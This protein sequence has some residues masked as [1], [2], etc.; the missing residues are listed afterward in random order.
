[1]TPKQRDKLRAALETLRAQAL[2]E[3]PNKIEP[4]RKHAATVGVEDE[5]EQA[6]NEMLQTLASERNKAKADQLA[7]ID[8]A[9]VRLDRAPDEFG[10]CEECEEEIAAKRLALMPY[11]TL[12]AECQALRDPRRGG[13]RKSLTDYK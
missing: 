2:A 11:A 3:G 9:L 7:R 12:C 10:F 5:D 6:L 4:N 13:T 1:M 8:R